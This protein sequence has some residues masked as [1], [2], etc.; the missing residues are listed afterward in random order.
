M[1]CVRPVL[2]LGT[3]G[4]GFIPIYEIGQLQI[5]GLEDKTEHT[6]VLFI[7]DSRGGRMHSSLV[8][9]RFQRWKAR[10]DAP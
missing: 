7:P 8:D 6:L 4:G 10:L 3:G 5:L 9:Y 1:I 2:S